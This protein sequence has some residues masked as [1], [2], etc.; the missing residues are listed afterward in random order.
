VTVGTASPRLRAQ[1][2]GE[3]AHPLPPIS[4]PAARAAALDALI[5][6]A[7][8]PNKSVAANAQLVQ[9]LAGVVLGSSDPNA[10]PAG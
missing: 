5:A 8:S 1:V 7:H 6:A 4:E 10:A 2:A 9:G 3:A